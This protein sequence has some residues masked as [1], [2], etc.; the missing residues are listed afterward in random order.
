[1]KIE[2]NSKGEVRVDGKLIKGLKLKPED[3]I[4]PIVSYLAQLNKEKE[5]K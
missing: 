5:S 4:G 3:G 1:M 2:R